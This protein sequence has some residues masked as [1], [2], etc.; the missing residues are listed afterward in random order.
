MNTNKWRE[1]TAPPIRKPAIDGGEWPRP[2][3][4]TKEPPLDPLNRRVGGPRTR[5]GCFKINL[6][7]WPGF[8]NIIVQSSC[9]SDY[10]S[11]TTT[12]I[13]SPTCKNIKEQNTTSIII[14]IRKFYFTFPSLKLFRCS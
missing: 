13:N 6:C 2:F 7:T 4:L 14:I 3:Y 8:E 10:A 1:I 12:N 9:Y 5:S 11:M